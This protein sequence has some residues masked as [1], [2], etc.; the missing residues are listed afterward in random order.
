MTHSDRI[1]DVP[2]QASAS[3]LYRLAEKADARQAFFGPDGEIA[4]IDATD[5][6]RTCFT[7]GDIVHLRASGNAPELRCYAEAD[8][9]GRAVAL[10]TAYLGRAKG[11]IA[12]ALASG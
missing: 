9:Q 11:E 2:S 7:S 4:A 12:G 10:V 3:L 1:K 6:L 5:G 8:T